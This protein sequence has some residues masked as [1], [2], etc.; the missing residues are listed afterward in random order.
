[1]TVVRTVAGWSA[2]ACLLAGCG[3]PAR[4]EARSSA[5]GP[6]QSSSSG[7]RPER[8]RA[9]LVDRLGPATLDRARKASITVGEPLAWGTYGSLDHAATASIPITPRRCEQAFRA[10]GPVKDP[11]APAAAVSLRQDDARSGGELL[12]AT[13]PENIA[14]ELRYRLPADCHR[15]GV[16]G[17]SEVAQ[18]LPVVWPG[19]R[20]RGMTVRLDASPENGPATTTCTVFFP[21]GHGRLLGEAYFSAPTGTDACRT[22]MS[23]AHAADRKARKLI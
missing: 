18:D 21:A 8:L 1:M 12:V 11:G 2:C 15:L 7:L 3:G 19:G 16:G 5:S 9:A 22:A 4:P 6:R 20:A 13:S 23:L 14:A 10:V 17:V